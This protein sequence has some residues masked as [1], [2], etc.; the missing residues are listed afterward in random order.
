MTL[1]RVSSLGKKFWRRRRGCDWSSPT[2]KKGIVQLVVSPFWDQSQERLQVAQ[3]I[4]A[5]GDRRWGTGRVGLVI[6]QSVSL[7]ARTVGKSARSAS[8]MGSEK[9]AECPAKDFSR[10]KTC[11]GG[12]H[13]GALAE[14]KRFG[15]QTQEARSTRSFACMQS[16]ASGAT[17]Q[18]AMECGFQG[19]VPHARWPSLRTLTVRDV[20]SRFVITA[21]LLPNQSDAAVRRAMRQVFRRYGLPKAIRV[22]TQ[23]LLAAVER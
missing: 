20:F 23:C 4:R 14:A 1:F 16:I 5:G 22:E 11:S 19:V 8:A 15:A 10:S 2:G 3:A 12:K 9:A 7:L 18:R 21:A 13:F 17:V 6:A